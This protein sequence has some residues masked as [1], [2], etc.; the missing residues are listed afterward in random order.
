VTEVALHS[1]PEALAHISA[2]RID[3]T[4][5]LGDGGGLALVID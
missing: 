3:G 4:P 2:A 5:Y 1:P